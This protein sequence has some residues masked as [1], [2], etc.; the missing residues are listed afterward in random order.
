[1]Q[2]LFFFLS[3][4]VL[5]PQDNIGYYGSVIECIQNVYLNIN[6]MYLSCKQS[7]LHADIRFYSFRGIKII[8]ILRSLLIYTNF[9]EW[10]KCSEYSRFASFTSNY[11]PYGVLHTLRAQYEFGL[12]FQNNSYLHWSIL[13][14]EGLTHK[15]WFKFKF[16]IL[17]SSLCPDF[18]IVNIIRSVLADFC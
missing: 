2:N 7:I 8:K 17:N 1:M 15:L 9:L 10:I 12:I 4:M 14:N 18:Y 6:L 13:P 3:L 11:K 5:T 16:W